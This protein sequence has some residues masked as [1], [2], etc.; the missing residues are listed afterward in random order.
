M[1]VTDTASFYFAFFPEINKN[2][3]EVS[4]RLNTFLADSDW[5]DAYGRK[6]PPLSMCHVEPNGTCHIMLDRDCSQ[7][8][9][10]NHIDELFE[11]MVK[12][13]EIQY[14]KVIKNK[15]TEKII[16]NNIDKYHQSFA[17][18]DMK[19]EDLVLVHMKSRSSV[20]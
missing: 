6:R 2:K 15:S 17:V 4:A 18:E 16:Y 14:V 3:E 12:N 11:D 20:R 10:S 19:D 1:E 7:E 8:E 5:L 9:F 13:H